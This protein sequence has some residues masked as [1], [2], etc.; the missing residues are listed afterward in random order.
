MVKLVATVLGYVSPMTVSAAL[1]SAEVIVT[2]VGGVTAG[3]MIVP[4]GSRVPPRTNN[5]APLV[6][7]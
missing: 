6:P 4:A 3:V 7:V 2:F 1:P 5:P